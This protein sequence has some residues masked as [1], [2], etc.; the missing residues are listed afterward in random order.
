VPMDQVSY[1]VSLCVILTGG[2]E[3]HAMTLR[4]SECG[5]DRPAEVLG[6]A[7]PARAELELRRDGREWLRI[8]DDGAVRVD[9][10][11]VGRIEPDGTVRVGG[12]VAG[13]VEPGGDIRR[14]GRVVGRVERDGALRHRG[15]AVGEV[16]DDG[17]IRRNGRAWATVRNC[18]GDFG[19][20]RTIAAVLAFFGDDFFPD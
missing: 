5:W 20:K 7:L 18:C 8:E 2:L 13:E 16:E 4:C 10:R 19:S 14:A 1:V 3:T 9:G 17:I 15:R 11:V 6:A 12:R